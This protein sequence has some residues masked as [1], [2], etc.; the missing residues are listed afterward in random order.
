M[1]ILNNRLYSCEQCLLRN[2]GQQCEHF[3]DVLVSIK[4]A[5][6]YAEGPQGV[7]QNITGELRLIIT[8]SPK[9]SKS[10]QLSKHSDEEVLFNK[11]LDVDITKSVGKFIYILEGSTPVDISHNKEHLDQEFALP[12]GTSIKP[13][14][15]VNY[16][17]HD[18]ELL[19]GTTS[20]RFG[21]STCKG[22]TEPVIIRP[23]SR[24]N[25]HQRSEVQ[26]L[27]DHSLPNGVAQTNTF[28][29]ITKLNIHPILPID[30]P[31]KLN[32][33]NNAIA[34]LKESELKDQ[35]LLFQS[36]K[37]D[38]H[39]FKLAQLDQFLDETQAFLH[40]FGVMSIKESS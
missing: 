21:R 27:K 25:W 35:E 5:K 19:Q 4:K 12:F 14:G 26:H 13:F 24:V 18:E 6:C 10:I 31:S 29:D 2:E 30:D 15:H 34:G 11:W 3:Q 33:S 17:V 37:G 7:C 32:Y 39:I 20:E 1:I 40:E 36:Q 23:F 9:V 16:N 22:T 8:Q 28:D 38:K